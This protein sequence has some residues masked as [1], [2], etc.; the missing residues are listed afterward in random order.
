MLVDP[1]FS[2]VFLVEKELVIDWLLLVSVA[3]LAA[4]SFSLVACFVFFVEVLLGSV[5]T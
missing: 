3:L 2:R 5:K 1:Y 4:E